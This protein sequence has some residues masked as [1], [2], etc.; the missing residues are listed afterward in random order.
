MS[1]HTTQTQTPSQTQT[2]FLVVSFEIKTARDD[3]SVVH[4]YTSPKVS[5]FKVKDEVRKY[6]WCKDIIIGRYEGF[7]KALPEGEV[8]GIYV[9]ARE[10]RKHS[11]EVMVIGR[12]EEGKTFD[13]KYVKINNI[14]VLKEINLN[15][16]E[17]IRAEILNAGFSTTKRDY[18]KELNNIAG[19]YI[20]KAK[21][22][23]K[24]EEEEKSV[25]SETVAKLEKLAKELEEEE[26]EKEEKVEV[27]KEDI[28][29]YLRTK[30]LVPVKLVTFDLP[31]EYKG[32]KTTYEKDESGKVR[33][34]KVF[35]VD[36][37]KYR[38]LRRKFYYVLERSAFKTTAGW[39]LTSRA[40]LKELNNIIS[41]L[42][43]LAGTYRNIW[44]IE[45]YM[46]KDYVEHQL[47]Q[48]IRSREL[49]LKEIEQKLQL[50]KLKESQ[51]KQL[52]RRL[53]ELSEVV[54]ALREELRK[55]RR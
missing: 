32:A 53:E 37:T 30:G 38:S 25:F 45:T 3:L 47:E 29:E 14:N 44:I 54:K 55:L 26:E 31:T 42:N 40:N 16:L 41:E 12:V 49:A 46:P 50:E 36:P 19:Y 39:V 11:K 15:N 24:E 27:T 17:E 10:S 35:S 9:M 20:M 6:I 52:Q 5:E 43:K 7:K 4:I 28:Y 2:K 8:V 18:F 33:E 13:H 51:K 22:D 48:Y 23:M 34:V 21:E 1:R